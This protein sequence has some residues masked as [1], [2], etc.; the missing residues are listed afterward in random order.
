MGQSFQRSMK[1]FYAKPHYAT[2]M[3]HY[4]LL[5][6]WTSLSVTPYVCSI[7]LHCRYLTP[8]L[9]VDIFVKYCPL[10]VT[11]A[12]LE[13]SLSNPAICVFC[14]WLT[15]I[16]RWDDLKSYIRKHYFST[17]KHLQTIR[18]FAIY[19]YII[20]LSL[21]SQKPMCRYLLLLLLAGVDVVRDVT[22]YERRKIAEVP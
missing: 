14:K 6:S 11:A 2:S 4:L 16:V 5:L 7:S 12:G 8:G 13:L 15:R 18:S 9:F 3:L 21:L 17:R 20:A 1:V 22:W 19:C 10:Q